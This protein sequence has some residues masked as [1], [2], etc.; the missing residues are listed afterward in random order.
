LANRRPAREAPSGWFNS[1]DDEIDQLR[2][3][4]CFEVE[5][6]VCENVRLDDVT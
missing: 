6:G 5:A 4:E 1:R 2:R 3:G